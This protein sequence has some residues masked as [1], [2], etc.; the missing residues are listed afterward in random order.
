MPVQKLLMQKTK[1]LGTSDRGVEN[2]C[3]I[4]NNELTRSVNSTRGKERYIQ[5]KKP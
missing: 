2:L 3:L 1:S 4:P 5:I